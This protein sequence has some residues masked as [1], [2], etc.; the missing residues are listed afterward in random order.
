MSPAPVDLVDHAL[1]TAEECG[2][3]ALVARARE[4]RDRL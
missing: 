1:A 4:L 2:A 3:K